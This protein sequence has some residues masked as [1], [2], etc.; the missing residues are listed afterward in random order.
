MH[1]TKTVACMLAAGVLTACSTKTA[2]PEGDL[3]MIDIY[4]QAMGQVTADGAGVF[5]P[6]AVCQGIELA[7]D[8][9]VDECAKAVADYAMAVY[10][11]L[12]ANRAPQPLDY[13]PYTRTVENE[14]SNLFPRAENPDL[15]I[16]VYPHL[17]TR[18]RAPIPGYTTVIP[19]Y[20]R[21]QYRL[22]G[23][24]LMSTPPA[25]AAIAV[26]EQPGEASDE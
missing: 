22:P 9:T 6:R 17:A 2:I 4:R 12:D 23:E 11:A 25:A 5:D 14:L 18:T 10:R 1:W 26:S 16:Y 21:V 13:K 3:E 19:L 7:E 20:D 15:V 8:E 24:A